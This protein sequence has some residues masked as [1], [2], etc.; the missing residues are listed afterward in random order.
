MRLKS[1][2]NEICCYK[3]DAVI[4]LKKN[5]TLHGFYKQVAATRLKNRGGISLLLTGRRYAVHVF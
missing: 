5:L 2:D 3:Q 1:Q 4:R